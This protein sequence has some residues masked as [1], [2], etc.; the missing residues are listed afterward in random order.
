MSTELIRWAVAHP[1]PAAAIA[2][3]AMVL[4]MAVV[5]LVV[6]AV[7][8]LTLPPG[9]VLLA[10]FAAMVCT[11]YSADTSWG[12]AEK[13]LGM[14]NEWE[15][16]A[17]FAAAEIAL[18]SCG[19]M[20]R[21]NVRA[22]TTEEQ[23]GTPGVPGTLVWVITGVQV[24]PCYDLSGVVGGTVRAF[25]GPVLAG[26]LW[27][28]AMGLEVKIR[29]PSALSSGLLRQIGL[30]LRERLLA[31]LGLAQRGRDAEQIARDLATARAVRLASR[32]WL[33]P[34]GKS[35]LA[36]A[37]ARACVGLDPNQK[38]QLMR[39]L[40]AR[41]SADELRTVAL[42]S[43][44]ETEP[45]PARPRTLGTLVH[46][47]LTGLD[48]LE[49]VRLVQA[50]HP[51]AGPAEVASLCT[52][53]GVVVTEAQVCIATG[54][55]TPAAARPV[56][57]SGVPDQQQDS[58]PAGQDTATDTQDTPVLPAQSAVPSRPATVIDPVAQPL[59]NPVPSRIEEQVA[60]RAVTTVTAAVSK[61]DTT[62]R[63]TVPRPPRRPTTGG[64]SVVD[65]ILKGLKAGIDPEERDKL[66]ALVETVHGEVKDDTFRKSRLRAIKALNE[67]QGFYP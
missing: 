42:P 58:V 34:W 61:P 46:Q 20:A 28:L 1:V 15:R 13:R 19:I 37:V 64:P 3:T 6:R 62:R 29:R 18:M 5:W 17:M 33:G 36:A 50:A 59:H 45:A 49:A 66:R 55:P 14:S 38:Q 47:A 25:I 67:G 24:I 44:W 10:G 57:I 26:L 32:R 51:D 11:A 12:F 4:V 48:P 52:A 23:R 54:Q 22:T 27:H 9:A 8:K 30:E 35:R 16:A 31:R 40:A 43:P 53:A 21:A 39:Q 7:R 60:D 56:T 65:T 2:C 41:R 63:D